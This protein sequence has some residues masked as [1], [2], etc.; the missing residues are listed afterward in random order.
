MSAQ[1]EV[2]TPAEA[3]QFA[4][5]SETTLRDAYRSGRLRVVQPLGHRHPKVLHEDLMRWIRGEP[6]V[7]DDVSQTERATA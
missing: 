2:Y 6:P 4:R 7:A 1:Q 3:A 5:V